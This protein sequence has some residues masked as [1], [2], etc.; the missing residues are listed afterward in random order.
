M[1]E[2]FSFIF[3]VAALLTYVNYRWLKLPSTIGLMGLA[4]V[5]SSIVVGSKPL[6][7]DFYKFVC[8]IIITADFKT[9]LLDVMLSLLLF[10]GSIHINISKL[11]KERWSIL[12]FA[13]LG[14]LISTVIVGGLFFWVAGMMGVEIPFI[15]CL[16]FGALISPTDPVAVISI[17]K[18]ANVGESLEMKVEGESLFNDGVGV[19]VF[20]GILLL[21]NGG[22]EESATMIASE[23]GHVFLVEA[24]GGPFFGLVLGWFALQL[25]KSV[26][27]NSHLVVL[28][29][30][31]AVLG[32]HAIALK[33]GTSGP[34]SMV[35]AG[36]F[37]GN[38]LNQSTSNKECQNLM[39]GIW[40]VLDESLNAVLFVLIG[41]SLHLINLDGQ[42]IGLGLLSILIVLVARTISVILPASLL[43]QNQQEF[44]PTTGVLVWGGLRGGISLALAMSL[45]NDLHGEEIFVVTFVVVVFSILVQGL[46]LGTVVKRLLN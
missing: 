6:F 45:S 46:S 1:F 18:K 8:E 40:S 15:H 41:L 19:V 22:N 9:L 28:L 29:S 11:K 30:I 42:L 20:T 24:I 35:V 37:I 27:E 2:S 10:A 4:L 25:M 39:N 36:L 17:L 32:G 3:L 13:S 33:I 21:A 26:E 31:A 43:K 7:P 34:L 12:L 16:L 14:V 23:I 38:G 5:V 44:W